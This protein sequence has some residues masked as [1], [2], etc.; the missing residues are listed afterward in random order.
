MRRAGR[1]R[2]QAEEAGRLAL[3]N[4][5]HAG[6]GA[7]RRHADEHTHRPAIARALRRRRHSR[8]PLPSRRDPRRARHCR[9]TKLAPGR[10]CRDEASDIGATAQ[11]AEEPGSQQAEQ[12]QQHQAPVPAVAQLARWRRGGVAPVVPRSCHRGAVQG[13]PEREARVS[14]RRRWIR[15]RVGYLLRRTIATTRPAMKTTAKVIQKMVAA[16]VSSSWLLANRVLGDGCQQDKPDCPQEV[17]G[18]GT[19]FEL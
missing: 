2:D 4:E 8:R 9:S 16:R 5:L 15:R 7:V 14:L 17:A 6:D 3:G 11:V 10:S 1:C 12:R 18:P 19:L 13:A